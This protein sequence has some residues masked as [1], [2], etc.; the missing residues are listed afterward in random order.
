MRLLFEGN[1]YI[2]SGCDFHSVSMI[3]DEMS[4]KL[5]T[6]NWSVHSGRRSN[7]QY[8]YDLLTFDLSSLHHFQNAN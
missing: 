1:N 3:Y 4:T 8:H 2:Y 7:S 6:G 5:P